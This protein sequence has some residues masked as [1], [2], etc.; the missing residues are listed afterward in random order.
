[1]IE[2]N[3]EKIARLCLD[4]FK[5]LPKQGKPTAGQWTVLAGL[6]LEYENRLHLISLATGTKCLSGEERWKATKGTILNDS[7][8]EILVR[9]GFLYWLLLQ[10]KLKEEGGESPFVIKVGGEEPPAGDKEPPIGG[11]EPPAGDKEPPV[12]GEDPPAGASGEELLEGK[13]ELRAGVRFHL[14]SSHPPCGDASIFNIHEQPESN[15]TERTDAGDVNQNIGDPLAI[16]PKQ[17]TD[18]NKEPPL[19]KLKLDTN[20]TGAKCVLGGKTDPEGEGVQYHS[21]GPIRTKPGRGDRTLSLSCSDKILKWN[22]LGIQGSLLSMLVKEPIFLSSIIIGSRHFNLESCERAFSGRYPGTAHLPNLLQC[23]EVEF[24]YMKTD[25]RVPSHDS[26]LL[27]T[28]EQGFK[29]AYVSGF[30][31]G[32]SKKKLSNPKSWSLVSQKNMAKLFKSV[33]PSLKNIDKYSDLKHTSATYKAKADF[34]ANM[35][36]WPP[37]DTSLANFS[38][39]DME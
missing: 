34:K 27:V 32:W 24:E 11:V 10:F 22:V 23:M 26:L 1:M 3:C 12:G 25:D 18:E 16:T 35:P 37:K 36:S 15:G 38:L 31:Q 9:R 20:R 19:K 7:H 6:V 5:K 13:F 8:A 17:T 29:E 28:G 21:T 14:Y 2:E 30:K 33:H 4:K 39:L